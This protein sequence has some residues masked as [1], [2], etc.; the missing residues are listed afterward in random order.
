M[1]TPL[2]FWKAVLLATCLVGFAVDVSAQ[3]PHVFAS[4]GGTDL[5]AY[6]FAPAGAGSAAPRPAIVVFHGG[7]WAEGDAEWAFPRAQHFADQGMVAVAAQY[8]LSNGKGITPIESMSDARAII[9]WMRTESKALGIDPSRIAAYGWSAGGHLAASA[10]L[11][12][13]AGA[14]VSSRPDAL[15]L[16]SPAVSIDADSWFQELL[17]DRAKAR[18]LSPDEHVRAGMPPTVIV[19]GDV[20][21]VTP[22]AGVGRFCDRMRAAGNT[23]ELHVFK[24][25]GHLFTPAGMRD[26][27]QPAPD[28][29]TAAAAMAR[30]DAFLKA[31]GFIR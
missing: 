25:F 30:A 4:P 15:V 21:T 12:E 27:R 22:L 14:S 17:G 3:T 20:D 28:R 16:S 7:G 31:L 11:F 23:C 18:D 26:D 8:R 6:V 24:G 19:Q 10:A 13:D 29:A 9:R 5:T 2:P 1:N